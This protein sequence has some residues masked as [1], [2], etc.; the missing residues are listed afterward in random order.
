MTRIRSVGAEYQALKKALRS[1]AQNLL[2]QYGSDGPPYDPHRIAKVLKVDVHETRLAG[3]EGYVET[4]DSKYVATIST[5]AAET[6]RRFTLAHEL[7]HVVLMR[8]AER[9]TPVRLIRFRSNGTLPG[10]H[11]DPVE[12]SLCNYFAAELLMPSDEIRLRLAVHPIDPMTI[13][14]IANAYNVSIQS[15][16]IQTVSVLK[17]RLIACSFWN[18]DSLWPLPIW[19]TGLKTNQEDEIRKLE[20]LAETRSEQVEIWSAY[21]GRKRSVKIEVTPTP[22]MHFAMMLI[23]KH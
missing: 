5:D 15:A 19:W 3:V 13:M 2:Q 6:R 8:K 16:A 9:G 22:A 18:L 23:K 11:Q 20:K 17:D 4:I 1:C 10:L 21:A 12:E 14:D 7:C